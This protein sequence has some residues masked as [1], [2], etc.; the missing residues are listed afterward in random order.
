MSIYSTG[1][2]RHTQSRHT[3]SVDG[4]LTPLTVS[5]KRACEILDVGHTTMWSLIKVGRVKTMSLG[6]KRLVIY[7]SLEALV[8]ASAEGR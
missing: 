2:S 7:S 6:R 5:V 1:V 4:A 3:Q 8:A